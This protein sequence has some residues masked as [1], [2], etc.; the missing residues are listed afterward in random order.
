MELR[1]RKPRSVRTERLRG[2]RCDPAQR[3]GE[4]AGPFSTRYWHFPGRHETLLAGNP[5]MALQVKNLARL[6]AGRRP[7]VAAVELTT[8][9][10]IRRLC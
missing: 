9:N 10:A 6:A 4:S 1:R 7:H 3:I 5:R 8:A 2:C